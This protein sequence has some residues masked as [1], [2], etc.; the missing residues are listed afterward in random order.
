M[1][2]ES[3]PEQQINPTTLR[4]GDNKEE[5]KDPRKIQLLSLSANTDHDQRS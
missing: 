1:E 4:D 3:K 2:P 5:R